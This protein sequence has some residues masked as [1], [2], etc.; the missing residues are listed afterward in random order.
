MMHKTFCSKE[1]V[2]YYFSG[3]SINFSGYTGWKIDDSNP[4]WV[5]LLG[6]SQLSNPSDLPCYISIGKFDVG[7]G[8]LDVHQRNCGILNVDQMW[9]T[10]VAKLLLDM[11]KAITESMGMFVL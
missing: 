1:E 7:V 2:P 9:H 3:S 10:W 11:I 6:R 4:I 5:R 8:V